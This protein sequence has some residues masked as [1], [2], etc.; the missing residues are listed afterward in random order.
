VDTS[1]IHQQAPCKDVGVGAEKVD[2]KGLVVVLVAFLRMRRG[3]ASCPFAPLLFLLGI[4]GLAALRRR[5]IHVLA[6]LPVEY[7]PHHLL[8]ESEAGGDVE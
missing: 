1:F 2:G 4:F 3:E 5:D 8:S 7:G 6:L